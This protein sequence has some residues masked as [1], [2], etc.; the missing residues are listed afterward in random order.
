[1]T[2]GSAAAPARPGDGGADA[3]LMLLLLGDELTLLLL[4]HVSIRSLVFGRAPPTEGEVAFDVVRLPVIE[5]G[6]AGMLLAIADAGRKLTGAFL[7]LTAFVSPPPE[8]KATGL[9]WEHPIIDEYRAISAGLS[10]LSIWLPVR[11]PTPK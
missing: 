8:S 11:L 9:D 4:A 6:A 7:M 1:M 5:L 10:G 2:P 3:A